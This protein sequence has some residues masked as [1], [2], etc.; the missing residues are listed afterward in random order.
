MNGLKSL[1]P[2]LLLALLA[3]GT[4][5]GEVHVAVAANFTAPMEQ[6]AAAFAKETG[7][8][9]LLSYG[10]TGKFYAQIKNGA[11]FEAFLAADDDTP[12]KLEREG[13][14]VPGSRFT[15]AVGKLALWSPK[16]GYVDAQG[17][18]L[19]AGAFQHLAIA[20]PKLAPY[21][22]AARELMERQGLWQGL[23]SRLV[24]GENI[25]QTY[26]F[27]GS[28]NAELGFVALSQI[29][30]PG[31]APQGSCWIVPQALYNP[32]RQ[33]VALLAKGQG[34]AAAEQLLRYLKSDKA[35]AIIKS[36]GYDL[37]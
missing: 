25:A 1:I 15:Y 31:G 29:S 2:G 20:N 3:A 8:K 5:A 36:F 35:A 7:H 9:L 13:M 14:A 11:P 32:I 6:I 19:K 28:G 34:N 24:F 21:G 26:Q 22:L 10:A 16:P 33:D 30:R 17:Q 18:V 27:V 37:P 12:A 23:Q 4:Q